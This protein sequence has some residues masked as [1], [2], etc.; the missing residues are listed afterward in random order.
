MAHFAKLNEENIVTKVVVVVNE[1]IQDEN[2]NEV[3][4]LGVDFL[5]DLYGTNDVWLQTS[6]NG[7]F[8]KNY[9][10]V[11]Y[12]Y[13]YDKDAF[14]SPKRFDSWILNEDTCRWESPTPYPSDDKIYTWNEDI[15][16]WEEITE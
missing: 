2:N 11:G 13:D 7:S 4:S 5:N 6:Y 10:G 9:A 14:I 3:E 16:N 1:V 8:R 12:T 15:L